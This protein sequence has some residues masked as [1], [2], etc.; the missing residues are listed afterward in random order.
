MKNFHLLFFFIML[1]F[2][3]LQ[4]ND[5]DAP[6]WLVIYLTTAILA[7]IVYKE[8]CIPCCIAWA[9]AIMVLTVY[10]LIGVLPGLNMLISNNAYYEIFFAMSDDKPYIEQTRE[11][12][13][14]FIILVYCSSVLILLFKKHNNNLK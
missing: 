2:A 12:L 10:I 4:W 5:I 11:S 3:A 6:I 14:L 9:I 13:G 7:F 8:I 1:F